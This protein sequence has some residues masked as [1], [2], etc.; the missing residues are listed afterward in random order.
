MAVNH[1]SGRVVVEM[2]PE[3][4]LALHAALAAEGLSLKEWLVQHAESF[5]RERRQPALAFEAREPRATYRTKK[6]R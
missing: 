2:D 1:R 6:D 5:V 4:K 3:L